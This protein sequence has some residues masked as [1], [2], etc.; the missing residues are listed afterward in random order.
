MKIGKK[1]FDLKNETYIMGI[2]NVTPDSF[3]D[4]NFY[5]S[6]DKAL[7]QAEKMISE[8]ADI[9]DVGGM[10]TKPG[11]QDLSCSEEIERAVPVIREIR[12]R[13]DVPLSVDTYRSRVAEEALLAGAD[14]VND[15]WGALFG[16]GQMAD[17]IA[18]HNVPCCL[19]HNNTSEVFSIEEILTGLLRSVGHVCSRGVS[20]SNII[21]DPG[22]GF[23]KNPKTN[24][25]VIKEINKIAELKLPIMLGA[26]RKS[27][28]GYVLDLPAQERLEGT[29]AITA[30]AAM[31]AHIAFMRV[32]DVKENAR[33]LK[34]L[35]AIGNA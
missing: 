18:K 14:M 29:L 3:Y 23:A 26:S 13:F 21:I 16:D 10:S 35:K 30:Y 22:I 24:L 15:I 8:G 12:R 7:R 1:D 5:G 25:L 28:I 34:M 9:I 32:H 2:L 19:M 4:G 17:T 20:K 33:V 27:V 11:H 31:S 6:M